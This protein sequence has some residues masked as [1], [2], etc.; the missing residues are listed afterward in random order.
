MLVVLALMICI[1]CDDE[2]MRL[3]NSDPVE[4]WLVG[5]GDG[6]L[7]GWMDACLCI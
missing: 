1:A 2:I 3:F 4:I 5:D 7:V 6:W